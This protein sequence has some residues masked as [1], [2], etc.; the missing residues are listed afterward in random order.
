[1]RTEILDVA[2]ALL[3]ET[4]DAETVSIRAIGHRVGVSAPSI[5]RHFPDKDELIRAV[6]LRG[7]E[8]MHQLF[9]QRLAG[10]NDPIERIMCLAS[11]YAEFGLGNPAQYRV[12]LM[13]PN[14]AHHDGS[15]P[16]VSFDDRAEEMGGLH[17]LVSTVEAAMDAGCFARQDPWPV[18]FTLWSAVHGIVSL[19]IVEP[20]LPWPPVD[21][22]LSML[23]ALL[24]DGLVHASVG[25]QPP[26]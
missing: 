1:L 23:F 14:I 9:D 5:Y 3:Y 4:A 22:Q 8:R 17:R 19:R 24:K 10:I 26:F 2:E 16:A 15:A 12:L 20:N 6:C 11:A 21:Q 7:F 13:S 25:I 18:A